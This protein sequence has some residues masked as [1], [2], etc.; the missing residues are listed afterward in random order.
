MEK[1]FDERSFV[2]RSLNIQLRFAKDRLSKGLFV[3][4]LWPLQE[5]EVVIFNLNLHKLAGFL[6]KAITFSPKALPTNGL[7]QN[8][9]GY[10]S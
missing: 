8:V 3:K 5:V 10:S 2:K 7:L 6:A 4:K 9:A 1:Y